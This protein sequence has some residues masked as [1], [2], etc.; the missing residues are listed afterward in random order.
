M[1]GFQN[2]QI[3]SRPGHFP[4]QSIAGI[5]YGIEFYVLRRVS[6]LQTQCQATARL[7]YVNL[8][9]MLARFNGC[10]SL[11]SSDAASDRWSSR[12]TEFRLA[13]CIENSGRDKSMGIENLR[14]WEGSGIK[15]EVWYGMF[16]KLK[17]WGKFEE[18][19][20]IV[21]SSRHAIFRKLG[22]Q[23]YQSIA[24]SKYCKTLRIFVC[25]I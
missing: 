11:R 5:T 23:V 2:E 14:K 17:R 24:N 20:G 7:G 13:D 1:N 25:K 10:V 12:S 8:L 9:I 21:D 4:E 3:G 18:I 16:G 15:R 22:I 19:F 6:R